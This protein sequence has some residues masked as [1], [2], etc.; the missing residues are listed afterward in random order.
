[1]GMSLDV[2]SDLLPGGLEL[3]LQMGDVVTERG[4]HRVATRAAFEA[5]LFHLSPLLQRLDAPHQRLKLLVFG[6]GWRPEGGSLQRTK[7]GDELGR[8]EGTRLCRS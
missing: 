6:R 8:P 3:A 1:M 7:A 5:V 2:L 4:A